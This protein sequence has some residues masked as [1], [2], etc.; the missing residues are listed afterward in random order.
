MSS[1]RWAR[2]VDR[3]LAL[4]RGH[5]RL[6]LRVAWRPSA[7]FC[8][9]TPRASANALRTSAGD[10]HPRRRRLA[11]VRRLRH[12]AEV[13]QQPAGKRIAAASAVRPSVRKMPVCPAITFCRPGRRVDDR[14]AVAPGGTP[15]A[16]R[17]G[18]KPSS[19]RRSAWFGSLSSSWSWSAGMF[20]AP[21][22]PADAER[23]DQPRRDVCGG[24]H[25]ACPSGSRTS[26]AR[27]TAV[28]LPSSTR[29]TPSRD[30]AA[31][32]RCGCGRRGRRTRLRRSSARRRRAGCGASGCRHRGFG[33][34]G[35]VGSFS[36]V[37]QR[38][39][40]APG[41]ASRV[42]RRVEDL[43]A[44]DVRLAAPACRR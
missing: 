25:A 22:S 24:E 3:H 44:V 37:R 11:R 15:A 23:V 41:T 31:G 28:I 8:R 7:G 14:H 4:E 17:R 32:R 35:S 34:H 10:A 2:E 12:L 21:D 27:P 26:P 20:H 36:L 6:V 43:L 16:A 42:G 38:E 29:T 33:R 39:A 13:D 30:R 40:A 5:E 18:L 1:A 9:G 19:T